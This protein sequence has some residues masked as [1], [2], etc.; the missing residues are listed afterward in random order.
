[1]LMVQAQGN[2]VMLQ[3][4]SG[5]YRFRESISTI[6]EKLAPYGFIRIHRSALVNRL[7]VA[8]IWS[9]VAGDYGLRLRDGKELRVTRTYKKNLKALAELWLSNELFLACESQQTG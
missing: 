4:E 8:E 3:C 6:E 9:Y 5:S 7:W 1:V 2:Y